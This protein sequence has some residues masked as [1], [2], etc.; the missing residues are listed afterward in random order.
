[1]LEKNKL[2]LW[3]SLLFIANFTYCQNTLE[4]FESSCEFAVENNLVQNRTLMLQCCNSTVRSFYR[5]WFTGRRSLSKFMANLKQWQCPQFKEECERQTFDYTDFT[6]MVYLKF[7]QPIELEKRCFRDLQEVAQTQAV[8]AAPS[9]WNF[10]VQNINYTK[11]DH[12]QLLHP[13][14]Q[15]AMLDSAQSKGEHF[16]E[17]VEAFVP[18]CSFIWCGFDQNVLSSKDISVWTCMVP[19]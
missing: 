8:S 7:C 6:K 5:E 2:H 11:L 9:K 16:H 19:Q 10:L 13:C 18:F 15:V 4:S 14:V 3:F 12:Y 17:V 1:M